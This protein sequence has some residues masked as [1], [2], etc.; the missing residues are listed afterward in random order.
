MV[1]YSRLSPPLCLI[2]LQWVAT[3]LWSCTEEVTR[4]RCNEVR[5]KTPEEEK[6]N[7]SRRQ[8]GRGFGKFHDKMQ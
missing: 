2:F 5:V 4:T 3:T 1:I 7:Q 6:E 8:E